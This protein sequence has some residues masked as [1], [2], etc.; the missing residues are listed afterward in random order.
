MLVKKNNFKAMV[1][2]IATLKEKLAKS[3]KARV[4]MTTRH[5]ERGKLILELERRCSKIEAQLQKRD[6]KTGRFVKR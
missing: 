4:E 2:E 3:E 5:E 6:P 1:A